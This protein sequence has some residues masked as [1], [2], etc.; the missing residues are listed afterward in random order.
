MDEEKKLVRRVRLCLA[1]SEEEDD[2]AFLAMCKTE[3]IIHLR[4]SFKVLQRYVALFL[5]DCIE[6]M[7][8]TL[9]CVRAGDIQHSKSFQRT[10]ICDQHLT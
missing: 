3:H 5:L 4:S 9:I 6:M 1:V 8:P 7:Y 10:C 2:A